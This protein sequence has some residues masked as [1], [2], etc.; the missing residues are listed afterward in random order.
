M[1]IRYICTFVSLYLLQKYVN[2]KYIKLILPIL[3]IILDGLDNK[4]VYCKQIYKKC[5]KKFYYQYMDKICDSISYLLL[6]VFF[7]FDNILLF[8]ILY[9]II[10]IIL[11]YKSKN[12]K[13]FIIFFDFAKEYILYSYIFNNNCNYIILFII[14]KILFEYYHHTINNPNN[15][16]KI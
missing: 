7:K 10:G 12:S 6:F 16:I 14:L 11:F 8:F 5:T 1:T 15:Y 2:K 13:W 4:S 3:L 9:R